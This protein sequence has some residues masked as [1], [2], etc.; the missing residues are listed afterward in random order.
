[1]N[2]KKMLSL[3]ILSAMTTQFIVV[4]LPQ[5]QARESSIDP[6]PLNQIERRVD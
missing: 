2:F 6:K 4:D 1:M 5:T 3:L